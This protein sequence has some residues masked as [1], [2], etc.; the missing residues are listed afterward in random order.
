VAE[1]KV[2]SHNSQPYGITSGPDGNLWFT[3]GNLGN[4]GRVTTKGKVTEFHTPSQQSQPEGITAGPDGNLWF[5]EF[6]G[7]RIGRVT[8]AG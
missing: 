4:V 5:T 3:E 6:A 8:T 7:N 2:P 1:Y